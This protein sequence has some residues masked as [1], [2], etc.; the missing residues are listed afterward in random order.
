MALII[1]LIAL[2]VQRFF[3]LNS[4]SRQFDWASPYFQWMNN[5]VKQI[6]A[7]HGFVGLLILVVPII[8]VVAIIFGV[9]Y[10]LLGF[11]GSGV[12]QLL[13][14]WYCL[15][16]RDI[17]KEPYE[18]ATV[19]VLLLQ[20]YQHIFSVLFW[21]CLFGPVGL[22]LYISV[23]ALAQTAGNSGSLQEYFS[24]TQGVLDWVPVRL[25]GLSFA[26][27]G[28]FSVVFKLWIS[29]LFDGIADPKALLI[30]WG[31]AALKVESTGA[32]SLEST[33]RLID[34]SLL[35]WLVAI[36]LLSI[37]VFIG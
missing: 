8:L 16:A 15:D 36:L 37:S 27:V 6:T 29:K 10:G 17:H 35:V 13:L 7:G 25:L 34:R 21:Y 11:I 19:D 5:K 14:V 32:D 22:V 26:L 31:Q 4:Y 23:N 30:E 12:L 33:I 2:A 9:A 3:Q 28:S 1:V 20:T 24:K 18:K